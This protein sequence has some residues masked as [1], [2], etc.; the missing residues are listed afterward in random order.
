[1]PAS[2]QVYS[3]LRMLL[4]CIDRPMLEELCCGVNCDVYETFEELRQVRPANGGTGYSDAALAT[5]RVD[6]GR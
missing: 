1:M 4:A 2:L 5:V 3:S 6:R